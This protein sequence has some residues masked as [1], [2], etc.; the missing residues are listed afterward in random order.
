MNSRKARQADEM[1][2]LLK[3]FTKISESPRKL[4][5]QTQWLLLRNK[6]PLQGFMARN[7]SDPIDDIGKFMPYD[8]DNKDNQQRELDC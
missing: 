1:E 2:V 6:L 8:S 3:K 4:T 5:S 7:G